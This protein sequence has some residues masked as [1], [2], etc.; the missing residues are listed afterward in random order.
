[1]YL[2]GSVYCIRNYSGTNIATLHQDIRTQCHTFSADILRVLRAIYSVRRITMISK[3][4]I[5]AV[6]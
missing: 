5:A 2:K 4:S 1:M 3:R 6:F